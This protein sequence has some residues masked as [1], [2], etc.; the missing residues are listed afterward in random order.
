MTTG[1]P[2]R[3]VSHWFDCLS[4]L[5]R[6]DIRMDVPCRLILIYVVRKKPVVSP[7]MPKGLI[8]SKTTKFRLKLTKLADDNFKFVENGR[9]F[10]RR[11]EHAVGKGEIDVSSN[12]SFSHSVSKD[13]SCRHVK[14]RACLRQD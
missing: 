3:M 13:L 4:W 9:K 12:F 1:V 10:S 11:V 7:I 2:Q 6:P 14:A 8:L 5:H